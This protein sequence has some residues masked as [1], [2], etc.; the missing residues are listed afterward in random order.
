M[1]AKVFNTDANLITAENYYNAITGKDFDKME[2]YLH[3]KIHFISPL[4]EMCWK[5]AVVLAAKNLSLILQDINI[6]S[7][8]ATGNQIMFAYDFIFPAPIGMLR[9]AV[10][11]D[12]TEGLISKIELFYD[13]K[14][15]TRK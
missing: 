6:R 5:D 11:M 1:N 8:F 14:L 10:L 13:S 2:S 9:A 12:F 7:K 4:A 3:E 15:F